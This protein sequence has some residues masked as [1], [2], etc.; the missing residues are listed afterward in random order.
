MNINHPEPSTA[1]GSQD[2]AIIAAKPDV[3]AWF[4]FFLYLQSNWIQNLNALDPEHCFRQRWQTMKHLQGR[5]HVAIIEDGSVFERAAIC[6]TQVHDAHLPRAALASQRHGMTGQRYRATGISAIFHPR[7]P[8]VPTCHVNFRLFALPHT[9][10]LKKPWW[11]GGGFDLTPYYPYE[12][13]CIHWH[14]ISQAACQTLNGHCYTTYKNH[15]DRYFYLRHRH[16]TRGIGGIFFD[17][18][19]DESYENCSHFVQSAGHYF[20]SAY[21]PIVKKRMNQPYGDKQR[22]F[23][24]LRRGRYV[25]YNLLYDRGTMFGLQSGGNPESIL[26]S[27]PPDVGW[28]YEKPN[29]KPSSPES[30]L[31]QHYLKPREW[32]RD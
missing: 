29:P 26:L 15:C 24:K 18:L 7:N 23:Q 25:E 4:D 30:L 19:N 10:T 22:R 21:Y 20:M 5:S 31:K 27:M 8:Y 3:D 6:V 2:M 13:D 12:E 11:F 28:A 17:Q 1:Y 9:T 32:L 14:R 16:E